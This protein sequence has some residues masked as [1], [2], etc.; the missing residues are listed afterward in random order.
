MYT[1]VILVLTS[2]NVLCLQNVVFNFEKGSDSQYNS[3]SDSHNPIKNFLYSKIF[4]WPHL[5]KFQLTPEHY[6]VK[7]WI[8]HLHY[9]RI[10][11]KKWLRLKLPLST[12]CVPSCL[13]NPYSRS[14]NIRLN[15]FEAN[16][17]QIYHMPIKVL[18][19]V[20]RLFYH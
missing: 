11:G 14:W 6:L 15:N 1:L 16:W 12:Y 10:F 7:T 3:S 5:G 4:T 20:A 8:S 18:F 13:K 17:T 9:K 2:V 19:G